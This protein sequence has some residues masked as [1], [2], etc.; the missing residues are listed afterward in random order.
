MTKHK[1]R[2]YV[3]IPVDMLSWKQAKRLQA[4]VAGLLDPEKQE[5]VF[6]NAALNGP[7][8]DPQRAWKHLSRAMTL[9]GECDAVLFAPGHSLYPFFVCSVEFEAAIR[10]G[11][12]C[13]YAWRD[14]DKGLHR[15]KTVHCGMAEKRE[16]GE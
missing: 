12:K 2:V 1:A 7:E 3:S 16:E 4:D 6:N 5:P 8:D 13:L 9:I 14:P 11:K 15:L 10:A